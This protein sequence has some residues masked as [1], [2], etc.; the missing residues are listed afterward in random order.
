MIPFPPTPNK[1]GPLTNLQPTMMAF[2]PPRVRAADRDKIL[3]LHALS[4]LQQ[5]NPVLPP[6]A[7]PMQGYLSQGGGGGGHH[8]RRGRSGQGQGQG[9]E[10][11]PMDSRFDPRYSQ[12]QA[13]PYGGGGG[14][15]YGGQ[16]AGGGGMMGGGGYFNSG[17][18]AA[19]EGYSGM[20]PESPAGY[21]PGFDSSAYR[22]SGPVL[23]GGG[24][25]GGGG[26]SG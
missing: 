25:G 20:P 2:P 17:M 19:V 22:R 18:H 5:Q 7:A 10:H 9:P 4:A 3:H 14:G 12:Q 13:G 8:H 23:G 24:G 1:Q 15:G 6:W 16:E 26:G 11:A 21:Y